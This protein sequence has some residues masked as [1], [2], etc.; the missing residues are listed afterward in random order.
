MNRNIKHNNWNLTLQNVKYAQDL[1]VLA[2][3]WQRSRFK[4]KET[5]GGG[6]RD[7]KQQAQ[8]K[9]MQFKG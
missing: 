2:K 8:K 3:D 5:E 4:L 7:W 6:E 9:T 1:E